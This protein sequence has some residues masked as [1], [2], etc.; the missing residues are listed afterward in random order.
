[1][2]HSHSETTPPCLVPNFAAKRSKIIELNDQ[3][4]TTYDRL[5]DTVKERALSFLHAK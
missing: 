2:P 5:R 4:R 3:L 1:M